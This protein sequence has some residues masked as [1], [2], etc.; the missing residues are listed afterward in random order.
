MIIKDLSLIRYTHIHTRTH[1]HWWREKSDR[2]VSAVPVAVHLISLLARMQALNVRTSQCSLEGNV[3]REAGHHPSLSLS[4]FLSFFPL[5]FIPL[6]VSFLGNEAFAA[7]IGSPFSHS[8][9]RSSYPLLIFR[10]LFFINSIR[11]KHYIYTSNNTA[12]II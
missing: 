9:A 4:F 7:A 8:N 1:T 3:E 12:Q 6:S 5:F 2:H 11:C 10:V